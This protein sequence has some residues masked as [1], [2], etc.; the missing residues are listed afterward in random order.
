M[1]AVDDP[2]RRV[3]PADLAR[4]LHD[5]RGPLNSLTMH[6]E[7]LKRT[8]SGDT[9][10]EESLRTALQQLGRLA[11]MVP[12]ALAVTALELGPLR[13]VDLGVL[14]ARVRETENAGTVT[15]SAGGWPSVAG[16]EAL[17]GLALAHLLRNAL[18]ATADGARFPVVTGTMVNG[19]ALV[20]VRD[21]GPGLRTTNPK[22]LFKLLQSSKPGHRGLGLVTV[23]RIARLHGGDLRFESPG[24]GTLVTLALPALTPPRA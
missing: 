8:V 20:Q 21:W 14:A 2:G 18:E 22:L 3:L 5:L 23:E 1:Q 9:G 24:E 17:L 4:I 19:E 16:D 10:A 11:E 12:A 13:P 6:L 7:V 15:I